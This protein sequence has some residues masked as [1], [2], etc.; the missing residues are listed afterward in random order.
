[1]IKKDKTYSEIK[2]KYHIKA[3]KKIRYDLQCSSCKKRNITLGSRCIDRKGKIN[4]FCE[5]C[6]IYFYKQDNKFRTLKAAASRRR[7]IFDVAYLFEEIL[8]D[9]YTKNK[10]YNSVNDLSG[11][12]FQRF[13][14]TAHDLY[15]T[16]F[17]KEEKVALE[18][19]IEQKDIEKKI[20][21][22]LKGIEF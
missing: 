10:N 15:N 22:K 7:R 11:E 8:M 13:L 19:V 17:T 2:L 5:D 14:N 16:L 9:K 3:K 20:S 12:E 1:M 6:T 4:Y 21:K 18:E